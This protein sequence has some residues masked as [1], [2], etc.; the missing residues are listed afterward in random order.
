VGDMAEESVTAGDLIRRGFEARREERL[1]DARRDFA[2]AADLART[3]GQQGELAQALAGLGQIARDLSDNESALQYYGEALQIYHSEGDA[4]KVAHTVRHVGDLHRHLGHSE[5]AESCYREAL[6]L[7]RSDAR[8]APLDVANALR[9]LAM[10]KQDAG[11]RSEC[12]ALWRQAGELYA[13]AGV[14]KGAAEGARRAASLNS[15][16]LI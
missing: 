4:L 5:A 10:L 16:E 6:E 3:T 14:E 7:Y 2:D 8:S 13:L 9:G 15:S 12:A 11:E 1:E